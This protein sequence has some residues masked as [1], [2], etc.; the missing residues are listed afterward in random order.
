MERLL[1]MIDV[2][3]EIFKSFIELLKVIIPLYIVFDIT[4]DLLFKK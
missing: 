2:S 4:G 3:L 1:I